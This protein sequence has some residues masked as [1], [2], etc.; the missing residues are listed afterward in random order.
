MFF[1]EIPNI[2]FRK[3]PDGTRDTIQLGKNILNEIAFQPTLS[4]KNDPINLLEKLLLYLLLQ[5]RPEKRKVD[6]KDIDYEVNFQ[7]I[8]LIERGLQN[9]FDV[10]ILEVSKTQQ[11]KILIGTATV[12]LSTPKEFKFCTSKEMT[13]AFSRISTQIRSLLTNIDQRRG[14]RT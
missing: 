2:N 10:Q 4:E 11:T 8:D 3:H 1:L 14:K 13:S 9:N 5:N 6:D 12:K 7:E